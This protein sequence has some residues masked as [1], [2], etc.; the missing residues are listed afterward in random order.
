MREIILK[1]LGLFTAFGLIT[2]VRFAFTFFLVVILAI[3][4]EAV[5][6]APVLSYEQCALIAAAIMV[7]RMIFR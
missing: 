2:V 4:A 3:I 5:S 7:L 6:G 1:L